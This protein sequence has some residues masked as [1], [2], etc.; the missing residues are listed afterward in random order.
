MCSRAPN[1]QRFAAKLAPRAR[2]RIESANL[3]GDFLRAAMPVN[4]RVF[5][6][7]GRRI[8]RLRFILRHA[9]RFAAL[10]QAHRFAEYFCAQR[11]ELFK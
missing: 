10:D 3:T 4:A 2:T 11:R 9:R 7:D 6:F 8:R 1:L 5:F